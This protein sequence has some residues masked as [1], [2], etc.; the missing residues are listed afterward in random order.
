MAEQH[1]RLNPVNP[2]R[3]LMRNKNGVMGAPQTMSGGSA[4]PSMGLSQYRGG[5][6]KKGQMRLTARK[7]YESDTDSGSD[8]EAYQ[9]GKH[10]SK[11]ISHLH[12]GSFHKSFC[13]GMSGGRRGYD[14]DEPMDYK[15][16]SQ[17]FDAE[18]HRIP[19]TGS[20]NE[21]RR[22]AANANYAAKASPTEKGF[23]SLNN[24]LIDVG[25]HALDN[26]HHMIPG[27][28][29][30]AEGIR[31]LLP[32]RGNGVSQSGRAKAQMAMSKSGRAR[33][34][35]VPLLSGNVNGVVS[36]K[37]RM[38]GGSNTGAYEGHGRVRGMLG[39]TAN[40]IGSGRTNARAAIVKKVMAEKGMKMIEA[41][42]YVKEHGLYKA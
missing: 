2:K 14:E 42:K 21:M 17:N 20:V 15:P 33:N 34:N 29:G 11:H 18:G 22:A 28:E 37:G 35:G 40:K 3:E 26:V 38:V 39:Q 41:S 32:K 1:E 8:S 9:M 25:H 5:G 23:L 36:G 6:T 31:S 10:L 30:V 24:E 7:A 13:K 12:G 4:T 16:Q 27:S 19:G